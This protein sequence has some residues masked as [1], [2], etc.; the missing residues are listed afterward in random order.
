MRSRP[1]WDG[2]FFS[3]GNEMLDLFAPQTLPELAEQVRDCTL[4]RLCETRNVAVPG[5]GA[6]RA[7]VMLIGYTASEADNWNGHP[8]SGPSGRVLDM[9]LE[10]VGLTRAAVYLTNMVKCVPLAPRKRD[11]VLDFRAPR[12]D[13][14][15]TCR[16][17]L[18]RE[19]AL[20]RPRVLVLLGSPTLKALI[21][22]A[23][24]L[25]THRGTWLNGPGGLPTIAT[26]QPAYLMRMKEWDRPRAVEGWKQLLADLQMAV[27]RTQEQAP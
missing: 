16:P 26:W 25:E 9:A 19:I 10:R 17:W 27:E 7:S 20:V 8:Y 18:E 3:L 23:F 5:E 2:A 12:P 14:I 24:K 4:C 13:E 15:R 1:S 22:P 11:G 6:V 21:D